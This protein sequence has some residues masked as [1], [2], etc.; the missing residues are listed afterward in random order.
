MRNIDAIRSDLEKFSQELETEYY[1]NG[2]GQK[3][4]FDTSS[5]YARYDSIFTDTSLLENVQ[6]K[7]DSSYGAE[8]LKMNY[9]YAFLSTSYIS[10]MTTG[11]TDRI[12][13]LESKSEIDAEGKKM[14]FRYSFV[15]LMNEPDHD[16]REAIDKARDHVFEEVNPLRLE[17]LEK[18]YDIAEELGYSNYVEFCEDITGINLLKLRE[19]MLNILYRTDRLYTRYFKIACK[20]ILGLNLS[21]VRKHDTAF[22]FRAKDFDGIFSQDKMLPA[23][24]ATLDGIGLKLSENPNIFLDIEPREKK[25]PRAFCSPIKVPDKVMLCIMPKGGMDDYRA[26]FHEMGHSQHFGNVDRNM[27]FEFRC[28]GDNSVTESYAFLFEHLTN[29]KNWLNQNFDL[30]DEDMHKLVTFT[31]FQTLYML[32]RYAAKLLYELEL[33]SGASDP[34]KVYVRM[35]GDALKFKHP[36]NQYLFDCD[37][38]FYAANYLRAW[39][40]EVQLKNALIEEFGTSW[41]NTRESGNFLKGLWATGQK[42]NCDALAKSLGYFGIDEYP[43]VREIEKNLRY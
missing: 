11:L 8:K 31:S 42:F 23:L 26:L 33:H 16:K 12:H 6:A 32:R 34:E 39:M 20:D 21:E 43:I 36:E 9:L 4:E 38:N 1:E 13:T 18:S 41:W 14:P 30:S 40:F 29:N 22:L 19:Q 27:P 28:L 35:L 24:N 10:R 2:S 15:A 3:D 5:I 25:S 17:A 7:R 37:P